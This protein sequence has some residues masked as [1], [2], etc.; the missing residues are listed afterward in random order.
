MFDFKTGQFDLLGCEYGE[1]MGDDLFGREDEEKKY[2]GLADCENGVPH[3]WGKFSVVK[4][5]PGDDG[6]NFDPDSPG[7]L[8]I[9]Q[10][11]IEETRSFIQSID[12]SIAIGD[13]NF[14]GIDRKQDELVE[15]PSRAGDPDFVARVADILRICKQ[16]DLAGELLTVNINGECVPKWPN[17][18]RT[19]S[20]LAEIAYQDEDFEMVVDLLTYEDVPRFPDDVRCML[21]LVRTY[22][23]LRDYR[24]IIAIVDEH[25][26]QYKFLGS[27]EIFDD[28]L[29]ALNRIGLH[30]HI[31]EI[32]IDAETGGVSL[33]VKLTSKILARVAL[34]YKLQGQDQKVCDVIAPY[35]EDDPFCRNSQ[36]V[37]F[38]ASSF[39]AV[40]RY[41][42][43][44]NLLL[45]RGGCYVFPS[46]AWCMNHLIRA[47]IGLGD[48]DEARR[49]LNW[50]YKRRN[51]SRW[52]RIFGRVDCLLRMKMREQGR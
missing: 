15:D 45:Y 2:G 17:N 36:L 12:P 37:S 49:T 30:A 43:A 11:I 6:E 48:L 25:D 41:D 31:I 34:A 47:L 5:L 42:D 1:E 24:K 14:L 39:N 9:E 35:L 29:I 28:Y 20:I 10:C 26:S 7:A 3:F 21:L 33:P 8:Y 52:F 51:F 50:A 22:I 19:I 32:C 44:C 40:G 16:N 38:V 13:N 18:S 27:S 23:R 46:D 4:K